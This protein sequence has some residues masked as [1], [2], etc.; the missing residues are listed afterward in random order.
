M[1]SIIEFIYV[2]ST[3]YNL[4]DPIEPTAVFTS[5]Y[6]PSWIRT[7]AVFNKTHKNVCFLSKQHFQSNLK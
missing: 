5:C 7:L 2:M 1:I 6:F 4:R 3:H